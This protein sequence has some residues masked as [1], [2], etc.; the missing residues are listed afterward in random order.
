MRAP[1]APHCHARPA[2]LLVPRHEP[3]VRPHNARCVAGRTACTYYWTQPGLAAR[4]AIPLVDETEARRTVVGEDP[5]GRELLRQLREQAGLTQA[6]LAERAGLSER[7]ISDIERGQKQ[8]RKETLRRLASALEREAERLPDHDVEAFRSWLTSCTA[9]FEAET[10]RRQPRDTRPMPVAPQASRAARVPVGSRAWRWGGGVALVA[11]LLGGALIVA[12]GLDGRRTP[13]A[14]STAAAPAAQ[15]AT[16]VPVLAAWDAGVDVETVQLLLRH[17]GYGQLAVTSAFDPE[18]ELAIRTFQGE[19]GLFADGVVGPQTWDRLLVNVREG[20]V[21]DA[22]V[23]VQV[24]LNRK[25]GAR[26]DENG[27]FDATLRGAVLAF[28]QRAR[29]TVDGIMGPETWRHLLAMQLGS[30]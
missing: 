21:G 7:A 1:L 3:H 15:P 6:M 12:S 5:S 24:Q 20:S 25:Q 11:V 9:R 26:L 14:G 8:P 2:R 23:A 18:T 19:S 13:A 27:Q 30:S 16:T 17:R 28:Q 10:A 4:T 22:V 29:I